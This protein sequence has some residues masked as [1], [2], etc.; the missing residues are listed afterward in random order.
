MNID[1]ALPLIAGNTDTTPC[2][3]ATAA[4]AVGIEN[5]AGT[6]AEAQSKTGEKEIN[7]GDF[8]QLLSQ[9]I[10]D[11][12]PT[13]TVQATAS[14]TAQA[15]APVTVPAVNAQD[16]GVNI[17]VAAV[18]ADTEVTV[19]APAAEAAITAAS[20][21]ANT[22]ATTPAASTIIFA[23]ADETKNAMPT[24][25]SGK[26]GIVASVAETTEQASTKTAVTEEDPIGVLIK[27]IVTARA[28]EAE[29]TVQVAENQDTDTAITTA[30]KMAEVPTGT[31]TADGLETAEITVQEE[32]DEPV[33]ESET[34]KKPKRQRK[35]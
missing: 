14:V 6:A 31:E 18:A 2:S 9:C 11:T 22:A 33:E 19:T 27:Q 13:A 26:T 35:S 12:A 1:G 30:D 23:D 17:A 29:I 8:A 25:S 32:A 21:A 10:M 4:G 20:T 34:A 5:T 15:A 7:A 16:A 28:A 3:N 24:E